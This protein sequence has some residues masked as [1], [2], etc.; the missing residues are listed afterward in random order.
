MKLKRCLANFNSAPLWAAALGMNFFTL[1]PYASAID[2]KIDLPPG[3]GKTSAVAQSPTLKQVSGIDL[4][5]DDSI[6]LR[7]NRPT[8]SA[9]T[10]GMNTGSSEIVRIEAVV[11]ET[12]PRPLSKAGRKV[13]AAQQPVRGKQPARTRFSNPLSSAISIYES[14]SFPLPACLENNVAFWHR[15]YSEADVNDALIHDKE[16]LGKVFAVVKLPENKVARDEA[17]RSYRDHFAGI[18]EGLA[19]VVETP[20]NWTRQQREA[21]KLFT[22]DELNAPRLR[23]SASN[24]RIQTGL[25]S[26]FEAGI[27]R[28][29]RYLP[30][31]H[32]TVINAGLPPDIVHLPHVESS[33]TPYARSKV[34]A[35]GMWQIMPNTMRDLMGSHHINSRNDPRVSTLAAAKLLRQ[36]FEATRS[37]PLALTAYNHGL[38]GVLRAVRKTGSTDLCKIIEQYESPSFRF[39]SSNFY[40]QFLAARSLALQRYEELSKRQGHGKIL[41]PVLA[42]HSK[43]RS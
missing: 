37:W 19:D 35:A 3:A 13:A 26:R 42:S 9:D 15:I 41:R 29:L 36:N 6:V 1:L 27:Q 2:F 14:K 38:N 34:G 4:P 43:G 11:N 25:R 31:V 16:D 28:S 17:I 22:A 7:R 20:S 21:A 18:L 39:A 10:A 30:G 12:A 33:Y 5:E 8:R 40:A 23:R 32:A 24:L